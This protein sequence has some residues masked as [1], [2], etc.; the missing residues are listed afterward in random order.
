MAVSVATKVTDGFRL[1]E[2]R[3]T[4]NLAARMRTDRGWCDVTIR[5][6]SS[7]GFMGQCATPPRRG[8]YIEIWRGE[9]C[10]VGCVVWSS[11]SRFGARSREK[12]DIPALIAKR[13]ASTRSAERRKR[14]RGPDHAQSVQAG[15]DRARQLG[16][17]FEFAILAAAAIGAALFLASAVSE[18]L[19]RPFAAISTVDARSQTPEN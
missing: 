15:A 18:V 1:R 19:S 6:V 12:I 7:G 9:V 14:E 3:T 4:V 2:A 8:Y 5:N 13:P 17:T 10:I 16:R 11:G